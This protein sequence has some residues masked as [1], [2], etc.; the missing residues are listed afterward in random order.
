MTH[1][2]LSPP[3]STGTVVAEPVW[4]AFV[5]H[6]ERIGAGDI[7]DTILRVEVCGD[8]ELNITHQL[9]WLI[10]RTHVTDPCW[11][12]VAE[13]RCGIGETGKCIL[14]A[15]RPSHLPR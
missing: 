11:R 15:R 9:R 4:E 13:C 6:R 14:W 3:P 1:S 10:T 12:G 8:V 5:L 2:A 7:S